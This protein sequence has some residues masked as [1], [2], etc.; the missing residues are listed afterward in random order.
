M[1]F[2]IVYSPVSR[3]GTAVPRAGIG[4]AMKARDIVDIDRRSG[5]VIVVR[6]WELSPSNF[7]KFPE[8]YYSGLRAARAVR[9]VRPLA[10]G[11]H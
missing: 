7:F 5:D 2:W 6:Q 11:Y 10:S 1:A 9:G 3:R 4:W 8:I